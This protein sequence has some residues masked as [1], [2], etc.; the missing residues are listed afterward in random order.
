M[1][2]LNRTE[3]NHNRAESSVTFDRFCPDFSEAGFAFGLL[4]ILLGLGIENQF[5]NR[6]LL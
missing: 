2:E 6:I 5:Q 3:D 1:T 4:L